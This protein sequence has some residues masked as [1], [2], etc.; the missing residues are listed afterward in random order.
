MTEQPRQLWQDAHLSE[1][2]RRSPRTIHRWKREKIL[3]P[4]D[5]TIN[6]R[7]FWYPETIEAN[8]RERFSAK[9]RPANEA[10]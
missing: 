6:D 4:P 10:A 1:R 7:D 2:Y 5:V 8:E 3:P 9:R